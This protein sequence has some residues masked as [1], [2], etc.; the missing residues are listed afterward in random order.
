MDPNNQSSFIPK[1]PTRQVAPRRRSKRVAFPLF[2][3]LGYAL[4]IGAII[5]AVGMF[6]YNE[7]TDQQLTLAVTELTRKIDEFS[8]T[9][10][11]TVMQF[12][13]RVVEAKTILKNHI[14]VNEMLGTVEAF[15]VQSLTFTNISLERESADTMTVTIEGTG[16]EFDF[17]IFQRDLL[18]SQTVAAVRGV[19]VDQL[20]YLPETI[21]DTE[22][23]PKQVQFTLLVTLAADQ[24]LT[25][26][27]QDESP[28]GVSE[29]G[30]TEGN[31]EFID[32]NVSS[33]E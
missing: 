9:D 1:Q 29:S 31:A 19:N 16:T 32:D 18:S 27:R 26:V 10:L 6:I 8:T 3:M 11:T 28:L 24:F 21:T 33:T 15:A 2:S 30:T 25:E 12:N 17:L 7:Y 23:T 20:T 4:F 14:S 13:Q 22:V 5:A